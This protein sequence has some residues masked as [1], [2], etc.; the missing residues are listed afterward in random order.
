MSWT[1]FLVWAATQEG[2]NIV[3][4]FILSFA[5]EWVEPFNRLGPRAQRLVMMVLSFVVPVGAMVLLGHVDR[6][7]VWQALSAGFAAF[8]GSQGA[9]VRKLGSDR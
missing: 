6:E 5:A 9:H 3:V 4:G 7:A 8:F 1:E 2:V